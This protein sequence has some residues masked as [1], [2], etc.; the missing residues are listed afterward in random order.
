MPDY[1]TRTSCR[2]CGKEQLQDLFSLGL[3]FISDFIDPGS[4]KGTKAPIELVYC[5]HCTL[6]QNPH[7]TP[8]ELLY[9]GHYWYKSGVTQTMRDALKD[10]A[11]KATQY[12]NLQTGD[13]ALDIG[14]NDGTL[15]RCYPNNITTVGFEPATNLRDEGA[16]GIAVHI[17]DF[18]AAEAYWLEMR[19]HAKVITALGM[20]YDL[21]DP[22]QFIADIADV[23]APN[24]IF[25]A[26][27]MCFQNMINVSDVGN[28]AHE[29]LEFYTLRSLEYLLETHG[30]EIFDIEVNDINGQSYRL[31]IQHKESVNHQWS[32]RL[33]ELRRN[34]TEIVSA[35]M[36]F[37]ED[38]EDNAF[39]VH[40]LIHNLH[41]EGK[42]IWI[43]GASTKGNTLLQYFD[44]HNNLITGASERSPEKW[45]KVTVGTNI[46]I[47]SERYAR[48][49][50]PDYF[51]VLPYAFLPEFIEREKNEDWRKRGGKFIV[52]L[53]KVRII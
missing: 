14:S 33:S 10:V 23:L 20:F 2:I 9:T 26:Q 1:V 41:I 37:H 35:A 25:I 8:Q 50:M 17:P 46:P 39:E 18:W 28:L 11:D 53:P 52:P 45:G 49:Q 30:L 5:P 31:M 38:M 27:L 43:Y 47:Y 12:A 51:L 4:N 34:E 21:E 36:M 40:R 24:G 44:L 19:H 29:H 48:E 16:K 22:N 13:I 3:H 7:T 42:T 32:E 6:I 15:L